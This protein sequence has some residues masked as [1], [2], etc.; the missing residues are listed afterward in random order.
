[1][2]EAYD[3]CHLVLSGNSAH[4]AAWHAKLGFQHSPFIATLNSLTV[5][6]GVIS[7]SDLVVERVRKV[8]VRRGFRTHVHTQA[9]PIGFLEF[10]E[11]DGRKRQ[12]G[13]RREKEE[14]EIH[15]KWQVRRIACA[16]FRRL[17]EY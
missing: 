5:D 16:Q 14:M 11:E 10:I 4:L 15:E 8:L 12:E 3:S 6:G 2:L 7:V 1:M 13:P 9:H 17:N